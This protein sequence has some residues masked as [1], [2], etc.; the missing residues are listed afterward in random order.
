MTASLEKKTCMLPTSVFLLLTMNNLLLTNGIAGKEGATC[1]AA[2]LLL[3]IHTWSIARTAI[4]IMKAKAKN[5]K[6]N[7][8]G[9][10][11]LLGN[12]E[13]GKCSSICIYVYWIERS[14]EFF[15]FQVDTGGG[16]DLFWHTDNLDL[17]K[18]DLGCHSY[19]A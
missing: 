2:E 13:A 18:M 19:K 17:H 16:Q 4:K 7:K 11:L 12:F 8:S 10:Y 6:Q 3:H 9:S 5:K 1:L 14:T 15:S